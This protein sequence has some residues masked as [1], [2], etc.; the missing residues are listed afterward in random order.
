M[1]NENILNDNELENVTGGAEVDKKAKSLVK[2]KKTIT[3]NFSTVLKG[4]AG[5][6]VS[7]V[8]DEKKSD[9]DGKLIVDSSDLLSK[10]TPC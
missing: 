8:L 2:N 3:N 6:N 10:G 9:F 1:I 4:S 5:T 7:L